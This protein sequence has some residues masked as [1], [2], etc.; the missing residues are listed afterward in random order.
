M[1]GPE[2]A[3]EGRRTVRGR[4]AAAGRAGKAQWVGVFSTGSAGG[5]RQWRSG[6]IADLA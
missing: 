1:G 3:P 4:R 6:L 2:P 5:R